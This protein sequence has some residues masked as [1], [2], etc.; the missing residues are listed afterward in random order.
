MRSHWRGPYHVKG[1]YK[2]D[3]Q[4]AIT[5]AYTIPCTLIADKGEKEKVSL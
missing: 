4:I 5:S 2:L 1:V 3:S